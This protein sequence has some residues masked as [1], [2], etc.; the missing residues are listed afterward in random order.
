MPTAL[1]TVG[2]FRKLVGFAGILVVALAI[3]A[4]AAA[5]PNDALP[6][7]QPVMTELSANAS[8]MTFWVSES[9]GWRVVTIVDTVVG[10]DSHP[11]KHVIARF[12][13]VLRPGQSQLI[14]VPVALGEQQQ[15]LRISRVG[16]RIQVERIPGV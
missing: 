6:E 10:E 9:D 3:V 14:S 12:S 7:R 4:P 11:E 15:V 2:N 5:Q 8:A 16:D 1:N 13:S